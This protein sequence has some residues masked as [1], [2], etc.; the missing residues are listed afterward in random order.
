MSRTERT[1]AF[2]AATTLLGS[3]LEFLIPKPLPFLRLGLANLP[4]MLVLDIFNFKAYFIL[5][6]L[7]AIGQGFVSGT[8]FSYL[9]FIS[10]AGTLASGL[11]MWATKR[12][13]K[14]RVS[15]IGCSIIGATASNLAQLEV[16]ALLVYGRA[17]WV[18]APLMLGLG[19][20]TSFAL[21]LLAEQYKNK[22]TLM[23][24]L[25]QDSLTLEK[26]MVADRKHNGKVAV[27]SLLVILAILVVDRLVYLTFITL[28][29]YLLQKIAGRKIR[30][31]PAITLLFSMLLLS[32]VEPYGKVLFSL[33]TVAFTQGATEIALVKTLRLVSL[34]AASQCISASNPRL[35]TKSLAYLPLTLSYFTVLSTSFKGSTGTLT[36]RVDYTLLKTAEGSVESRS[37]SQKSIST[38]LFLTLAGITILVAILSKIPLA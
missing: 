29:L 28:L 20:I 24:L 10:L 5:L 19:L 26:P 16:A 22:S 34:L 2:V 14:K 8:L 30:I 1:I 37:L 33:G 25:A 4:I 9:F 12:L 13:F 38:P 11:V 27:A 6:L 36:Q 17:I 23:P 31:V 18:A 32:L 35:E 3:T 7:K 15:L 21:G